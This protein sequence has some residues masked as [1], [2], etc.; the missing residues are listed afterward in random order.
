MPRLAILGATGSLGSHVARIAVDKGYDTSV[1]VRSADRLAP[2]VRA[3]VRILEA[4][5]RDMPSGALAAFLD[6]HDVMI[7][8][9]G[10]VT[11]GPRFVDL[12]DRV[13]SEVEVMAPGARPV[14]WFLAGAG[15]LDLDATGR[16]GLDFPPLKDTYWPHGVNHE[17][18]QRSDL[19]W[20]LL[21]PGPMV[22]QPPVGAERLRM[23]VDR[24]PT[25]M[26]DGVEALA[27]DALLPLF[28]ARIPEMIIPYADAAAFMLSHAAPGSDL[29]RKR[30]G[31]A[32]PVGLRGHKEQWTAQVKPPR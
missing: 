30:V 21:C 6:G 23:S 29:R 18:L 1:L 27:P 17:R 16:R 15:L 14:C 28:A 22:D 2:D 11:E 12:F 8:C 3:R 26:P 19:D 4:D 13:V 24:L 7:S 25:P 10:L 5:I 9:A 20:R 32:L 31:L